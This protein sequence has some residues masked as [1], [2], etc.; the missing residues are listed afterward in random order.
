ML[1]Q[2]GG[3]TVHRNTHVHA[4]EKI[5]DFSEHQGSAASVGHSVQSTESYAAAKTFLLSAP[6]TKT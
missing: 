2:P 6:I 3:R 1:F 5:K 4:E